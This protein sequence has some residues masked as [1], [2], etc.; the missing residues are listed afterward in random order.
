MEFGVGLGTGALAV[1]H[2]AAAGARG[3][4][5]V[6]HK[7]SL[8]LARHN[9][10]QFIRIAGRRSRL[11]GYIFFTHQIR[12]G[13]PSSNAF[14]RHSDHDAVPRYADVQPPFL[15]GNQCGGFFLGRRGQD[16]PFFV[17]FDPE[18]IEHALHR[19]AAAM[20]RHIERER[21]LLADVLQH[22]ECIGGGDGYDVVHALT[23]QSS[24]I[25]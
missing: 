20:Q 21:E 4:G 14:D 17:R 13:F 19:R 18:Q 24:M 12:H 6:H 8:P 3:A 7:I 9:D 2:R 5:G 23:S 1:E 10:D 25:S 22:A 15:G 11:C 16:D